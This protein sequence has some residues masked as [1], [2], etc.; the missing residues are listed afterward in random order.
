MNH[1]SKTFL[2][3][4][5]IVLLIFGC[6]KQEERSTVQEI[7]SQARLPIIDMH[8]HTFQWNRYGDPPPPN[9]VSGV[10]PTARTDEEAIEAYL[11]E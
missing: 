4:A 9:Q 10:V 8:M 7:S 5:L 2:L 11:A 3:L 1:I 6:T